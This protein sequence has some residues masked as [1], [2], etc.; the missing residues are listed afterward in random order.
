MAHI[1]GPATMYVRSVRHSPDIR[2]SGLF[3]IAAAP[4]KRAYPLA[5]LECLSP[6]LALAACEGIYFLPFLYIKFLACIQTDNG[7]EATKA[8]AAINSD[9]VIQTEDTPGLGLSERFG[10]IG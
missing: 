1:H 8:A 5:T 9:V 10:N 4:V 7:K 6:L 2:M 3:C